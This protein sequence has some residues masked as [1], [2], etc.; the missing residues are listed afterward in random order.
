MKYQ[1]PQIFNRH[2]RS[3]RQGKISSI[4]DHPLHQLLHDLLLERLSF[5]RRP[6]ESILTIGEF[7]LPSHYAQPI[8][9]RSTQ[10]TLMA[11]SDFLPF[12]SEAFDLVISYFDLHMINDI[13]GTLSQIRHCLKPDGLFLGVF[14]GGDSLWQ[15]RQSCQQAELTLKNGASPRVA[16]MVSLYDAAALLQRA[17]FSLP[18]ADHEVI[19]WTYP[20]PLDLLKD[21]KNLGL[22]NCLWQQP[23]GL[24]GK[25]LFQEILHTY[26]K[27]HQEGNGAV[28]CC[29]D[30]VFLNGWSPS[31][32]QQRPLKR[33]S[34]T[35]S[36]TSV[37]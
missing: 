32:T 6:F 35:Q 29:Y 34:A 22:S 7:D 33:G 11:E 3:L 12:Q 2:L 26:E 5:V 17:G 24:M 10:P 4:Q 20:S 15:L 37:L 19:N 23:K 14:L 25:T 9:I 30:I 28:P 27:Q 31:P 13:P 16:P 21:L 18:V 1:I 36:L 8:K